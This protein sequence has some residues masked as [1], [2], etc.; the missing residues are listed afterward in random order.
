MQSK[1]A[2]IGML[3]LAGCSGASGSKWQEYK[4]EKY[5]FSAQF[6]RKVTMDEEEGSAHF[7][8]DDAADFRIVFSKVEP[9]DGKEAARSELHRVRDVS[10]QSLNATVKDTKDTDCH[11]LPAIEFT[12]NVTM[13]GDKM[14][15]HSR[16]VRIRDRFYQQL[17]TVPAG[18][19][20]DEDVRKFFDSF[21]VDTN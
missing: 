12:F 17:V 7:H 3:F 20:R 9:L 2:L 6:P 11:G 4:S 5:K 15:T 1:A 10:A 18:A 21:R 14:E 8:A 19:K 13:D 16:Y